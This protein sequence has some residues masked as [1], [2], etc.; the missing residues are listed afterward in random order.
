MTKQPKYFTDETPAS[1]VALIDIAVDVRAEMR[2]LSRDPRLSEEQRRRAALWVCQLESV[3]GV[4]IDEPDDTDP[5]PKATPKQRAEIKAKH[6]AKLAREE[7]RRAKDF[8]D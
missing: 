8:S 3:V 5:L 1:I 7:R 2:A 4:L 6:A